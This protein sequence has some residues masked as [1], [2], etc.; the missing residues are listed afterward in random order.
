MST[1]LQNLLLIDQIYREFKKKQ[2]DKQNNCLPF[3]T[4]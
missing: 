2:V 3:I 1:R 4:D